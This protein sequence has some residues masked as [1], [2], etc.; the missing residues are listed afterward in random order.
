LARQQA[1]EL[2]DAAVG[3]DSEDSCCTGQNHMHFASGFAL[4]ADCLPFAEGFL[5]QRRRGA[6]RDQ[7]PQQGYCRE[8]ELRIC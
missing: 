6:V 2:D 1:R 5:L 8:A 7:I 3:L 4:S